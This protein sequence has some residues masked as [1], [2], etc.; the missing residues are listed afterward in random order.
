M[1]ILVF[2]LL[3]GVIRTIGTGINI[4]ST[5]YKNKKQAIKEGRDT[6]ID[7]N[8][9]LHHTD[10]DQPYMYWNDLN[11]HE[12]WE[13]NPYNHEKIKNITAENRNRIQVENKNKAIN[14]GRVFYP[15]EQYGKN[16]KVETNI[17]DIVGYRYKRIDDDSV[18]VKRTR[19]GKIKN[20]V[21]YMNIHT[22]KF[23]YWDEK[24]VKFLNYS[25]DDLIEEMKR[26][27]DEQ[28]LMIKTGT[29]SVGLPVTPGVINNNAYSIKFEAYDNGK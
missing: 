19:I 12:I 16:H 20:I 25:Q 2:T 24:S 26:L 8:F 4:N 5:N 23:E 27:N 1:A 28:E 6:Y 11:T 22:K 17:D 21:W 13:I 9:F 14:E 10:T 15:I 7:H 3:A 29:S 18:Y